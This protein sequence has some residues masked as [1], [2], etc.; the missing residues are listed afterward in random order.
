MGTRGAG[1]I[2]TARQNADSSIEYGYLHIISGRGLILFGLLL[3]SGQ[4]IAKFIT[5]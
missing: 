3:V 1:E 2:R 4:L 5:E